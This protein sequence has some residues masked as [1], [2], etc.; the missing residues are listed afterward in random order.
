MWPS[1]VFQP[2]PLLSSL[3]GGKVWT[4]PEPL[5]ASEKV[6]YSAALA[7]LSAPMRRS[8]LRALAVEPEIEPAE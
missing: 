4:H 2:G 5:P 8:E 1:I 6:D 3:V 7:P